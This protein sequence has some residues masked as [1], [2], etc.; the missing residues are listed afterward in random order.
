MENKEGLFICLIQVYTKN[1]EIL[2]STFETHACHFHL[3]EIIYLL[4]F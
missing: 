2:F 3:K 4:I 1:L